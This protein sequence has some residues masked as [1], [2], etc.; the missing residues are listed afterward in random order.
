[1]VR[2]K[3]SYRIRVCGTK[4]R[5]TWR[6]PLGF[7]TDRHSPPTKHRTELM[8]KALSSSSSLRVLRCQGAAKHKRR[9]ETQAPQRNTS[10]AR[11]QARQALLPFRSLDPFRALREPDRR[12]RDEERLSRAE[13]RT[14]N[15]PKTTN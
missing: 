1:M 7:S 3:R 9:G 4:I 5:P 12:Q 10:A 8:Q 13:Q 15:K 2:I 11:R 6:A 14:H